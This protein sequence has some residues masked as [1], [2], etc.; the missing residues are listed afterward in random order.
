MTPRSGR[1]SSALVTAAGLLTAVFV[2]SVIPVGP[3]AAPASGTAAPPAAAPLRADGAIHVV[4]DGTALRVDVQ[5]A[6]PAD[7][8]RTLGARSR[9]PVTVHGELPGRITRAFHAASVE[10]AVREVVRG[11]S[12]A[13]VFSREAEGHDA[14]PSDI[15]IIAIGNPPPEGEPAEPAPASPAPLPRA[16]RLDAVRV[17]AGTGDV[18]AVGDLSRVLVEDR[19]PVVRARAVIALGGLG[20]L[21]AA[22]PLM[23]A[24]D[25]PSPLVR[26]QAARALGRTDPDAAVPELGVVLVNDPDPGVRRVAARTLRRVGSSK[27]HAAL[28]SAAGESDGPVRRE[29]TEALARTLA[30]ER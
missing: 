3:V 9:V 15:R 14:R 7:V 25:D 18:G 19:D 28:A 6:R 23:A 1:S 29:I 20:T 11:Y 24:L 30:R 5:D 16:S 27:A 22:R 12:A 26:M 10:D 21:R 4:M 17:L 8:L 2:V 13:L